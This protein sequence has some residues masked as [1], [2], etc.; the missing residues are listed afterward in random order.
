[1][2]HLPITVQ[3]PPTLTVSQLSK[4]IKLHLE[5][6]FPAVWVQGEVWGPKLQP[7]GHFY[8]TLKDENSQ[9][10]CVL[11]RQD[12]GKNLLPKE[13]ESLIVFGELNVYAQGGR[14]QILCHT[15]KKTGIGELLVLLEE[16]KRLFQQR[17][18]FSTEHKIPIPFLPKKIGVVTSPTGAVIRDIHQVLSRRFPGASLL[19]YPVS[20]QGSVAA[21]EIAQAI[22]AMNKYQLADV[23]IVGRGGGSLEDLWPFNEEIVCKAVFESAIPII[24][25]VGHETDHTLAEYVADKRASTPSAAAEM[26]LPEKKLLQAQLQKIRSDN[27]YRLLQKVRYLKSVLRSFQNTSFFTTPLRIVQKQEQRLDELKNKLVYFFKHAAANKKNALKELEGK[28]LA[29]SP[30]QKLYYQKKRLS[31]IKK[32]LTHFTAH[33]FEKKHRKLFHLQ[34]ILQNIRPEKLLDRGYTIL[35]SEKTGSVIKSINEVQMGDNIT[36]KL[37]DGHLKAQVLKKESL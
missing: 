6:S 25:A 36:V 30:E 24:C 9:I 17:G 4:A 37:V 22:Y 14:Y 26:V 8:F 7:S 3:E 11:F 29:R 18:W 19:L 13:G 10:A 32:L 21:K 28:V 23:L 33:A 27:E 31:E 1:M 2:E 5:S 20:V 35:F 15:L 12:R 34:A 16:R